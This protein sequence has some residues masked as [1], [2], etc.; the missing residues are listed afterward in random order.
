MMSLSAIIS[1]HVAETSE[2]VEQVARRRV[3]HR[4]RARL[5]A[6]DER[7]A[8]AVLLGTKSFESGAE[9]AD[10]CRLL[11]SNIAAFT[12]IEIQSIQLDTSWRRSMV[13]SRPTSRESR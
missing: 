2:L 6:R 8:P 1:A 5:M 13:R 12:R 10:A 4:T 9:R 11:V 3:P 7:G